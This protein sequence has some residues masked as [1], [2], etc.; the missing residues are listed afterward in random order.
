M[1]LT[2]PN[3]AFNSIAKTMDPAQVLK[4]TGISILNSPH[5]QIPE[6]DPGYTS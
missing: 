1:L 2:R 5:D 3:E 4:W 6:S